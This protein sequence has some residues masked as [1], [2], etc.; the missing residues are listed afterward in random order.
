VELWE[1]CKPVKYGNVRVVTAYE[2]LQMSIDIYNNVSIK[3]GGSY[4]NSLKSYAVEADGKIQDL[5]E[6]DRLSKELANV[7]IAVT[8][9]IE[10]LHW[11]QLAEKYAEIFWFSKKELRDEF[12]L[13]WCIPREVKER[14]KKGEVN[15]RLPNLSQRELQRM[16]RIAF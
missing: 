8:T 7:M 1:E 6:V 12:G 4:I 9:K 5:D 15:T 10:G 13:D 11:R 16:L 3:D 14:I 2:G